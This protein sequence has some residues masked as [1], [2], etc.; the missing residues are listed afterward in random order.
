MSKESVSIAVVQSECKGD[1]VA[2]RAEAT[3][4][5]REAAAL[6]AQII[7][8]QELFVTRYFCQTEAYEPFGEA[9]AIPDGA[10]TRLM[11][12]LAAEL[13]V[14]IIAS[15]FERR[16]RGLH[17]N[18]AVV[19][20]ADGSYLGMYRKMHIPDDPGFYEKFYF[21]PSD[22]G[23]KVFKTRYAT[24]GVLICWDQW[25]PEAARLTALK[26]AEILFYPTAIGWATDEDSAEVRHAQ[27]NAWIT[28]QRSHAIANGVFVA[29]A[30]R[31]GTEENLE[32]WG[33]SFISDPFGQMVAEA[34]HQHETILLAQCDLSRINFYRSHWPFLRDRRIETYGGLQQ[35]FLDNNQ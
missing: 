3:A 34:P 25:Y 18:T 15:L 24:I 23:Y 33:N 6:G 8:L 2:N 31:V 29:A 22:L 14:V 4:K 30:N 19:I 32:F 28:M 16:A 17:H 26:G 1:A 5:I 7:C 11:Q 27:Q 10:T 13:G 21:T 35:R 12:E 9:E 20:D